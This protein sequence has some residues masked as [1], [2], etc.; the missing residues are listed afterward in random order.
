MSDVNLGK[1]P[2]PQA[3]RDAVHV[4][5]VPVFAHELL[6]PGQRV[7]LVGENLIG[8][9]SD[10]VGI[11]D[12]YLTDVVPKG[13]KCWLF[14]LPNTVTGMRHHWVHPRFDSSSP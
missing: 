14:L 12:P 3:Q 9:S 11:V 8:P 2:G 7:G 4:A 5:V 10:I 6:R 13:E 1:T